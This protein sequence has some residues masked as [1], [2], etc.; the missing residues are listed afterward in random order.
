MSGESSTGYVVRLGS[1]WLGR[2]VSL[3]LTTVVGAV[4]RAKQLQGS[5][6]FALTFMAR[7]ALGARCCFRGRSRFSP[8]TA[9]CNHGSFAGRAFGDDCPRP[10]SHSQL[11]RSSILHF[12][13]H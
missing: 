3:V 12:I 11:A 6:T 5:W 8:Q 4:A 9:V 1:P 10:P 7:S 13:C 2:R